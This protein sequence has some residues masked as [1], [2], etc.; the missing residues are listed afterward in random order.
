M[1][2]KSTTVAQYLAELPPDRRA[3]IEA[4]RAV[5]LRNLDKD[6][7]EGLSYGMIGYFVPHRVFPAGYHCNPK[8]PLPFAGLASQKGHMSLHLMSA[9]SESAEGRW[10]SEQFAKAGKTLDM[11]KCCIRFKRLEDLALE[12]IGEAIRRVPAS[13]YVQRYLQSLAGAKS[14]RVARAAKAAQPA[15]ISASARKKATRGAAGTSAKTKAA[16][17]PTTRKASGKPTSKTTPT[18]KAA[19]GGSLATRATSSKPA[20]SRS[21]AARTSPATRATAARRK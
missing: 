6:Y 19:S 13:V 2:S 15:A 17:E 4:V 18:K 1:Q 14:A 8:M 20:S 11:G 9:Y 5:V 16:A 21:S 7:E 10:L 12:A 3:A